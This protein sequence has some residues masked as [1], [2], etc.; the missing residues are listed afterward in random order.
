MR[1]VLINK[2]KYFH[3]IFAPFLVL[4]AF[5]IALVNKSTLFLF[6]NSYHTPFADQA[7]YWITGLGNGLVFFIVCLFVL[8][9]NL[10][11][12]I[13]GFT[14]F[15]VSSVI[16]QIMKKLIFTDALRP[17]KYF[18]GINTIH[19]VD[20]VKHHFYH[21]FPSGH[22]STVFAMAL[23]ITMIIKDKRWGLFFSFLA[24]ITAYSRVYLAQHF[25]GDIYVGSIIGFLSALIVFVLM[26]KFIKSKPKLNKGIL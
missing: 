1:E 10:G 13:I 2:P 21:S 14:I 22:S 15:T 8:F 26:N 20:G 17:A 25:F 3:F 7:F 11:N 23:F 5:L 9:K 16:P 4:G 24:I 6:F 12:G 18:E 19:L